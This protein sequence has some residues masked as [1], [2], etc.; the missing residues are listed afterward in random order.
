MERGVGHTVLSL[1]M[2]TCLHIWLDVGCGDLNL[3]LHG[4][5]ASALPTEKS[6][7]PQGLFL[8]ILFY[9]HLPP[10]LGL[11]NKPSSIFLQFSRALFS[12]SSAYFSSYSSCSLLFYLKNLFF[13]SSFP[14]SAAEP[15]HFSYLVITPSVLKFPSDSFIALDGVCECVSVCV[16]TCECVCL[17]MVKLPSSCP[18]GWKNIFVVVIDFGFVL[19]YLLLLL[20]C[21]CSQ[22]V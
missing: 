19:F 6:P 11:I 14:L 9:C 10:L 2:E 5:A 12:P 16:C 20:P 17:F 1:A 22:L 4:P 15:S 18:F 7:C 21:L 3:G 8:Q 13:I